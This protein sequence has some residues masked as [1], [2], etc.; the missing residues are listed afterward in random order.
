MVHPINTH[1][2]LTQP[3]KLPTSLSRANASPRL[4]CNASIVANPYCYIKALCNFHHHGL[5]YIESARR[6]SQGALQAT[7]L[8]MHIVL[9]A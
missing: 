2:T 6:F 7:H 4:P 5:T 8:S 3:N 1:T 9:I